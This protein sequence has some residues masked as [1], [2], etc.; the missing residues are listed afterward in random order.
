MD[1]VELGPGRGTLIRDALKVWKNDTFAQFYQSIKSVNLIERSAQLRDKQCDT[2]G[3][4]RD[5]S[6]YQMAETKSANGNDVAVES[7]EEIMKR[8]MEDAKLMLG[9]RLDN[10]LG[11]VKKPRDADSHPDLEQT[12]P[13]S[14]ST[15]TSSVD[16]LTSAKLDS[17]IPVRWHHT[18]PEMESSFPT[19]HTTFVICQEL[20]DALPIHVFEYTKK[21]WREKLVDINDSKDGL[22]IVLSKG[23]TVAC[24]G[25]LGEWIEE[26]GKKSKKKN[27]PE[28]GTVVEVSPESLTVSLDIATRINRNG[29]AAVIVDYGSAN[30]CGGETLRGFLSHNEVSI[31]ERPGE[32][33]VTGDVDFRRIV[34]TIGREKALDSV[35]VD[36]VCKQG[37]W[38][39]RMGIGER[40]SLLI[41]DDNVSEEQAN[42][43]YSGFE[44]LVGGSEVENGMGEVY[45]VLTLR[46]RTLRG[47]NSE[48]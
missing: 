38:L 12:V 46:G 24:R 1:V 16:F 6:S 13:Q 25:L 7:E 4:E 11:V 19:D 40:A 45:K 48:K 47:R 3:A 37:E 21:G 2:L 28:V 9:A 17:K 23:V 10:D 27:S 34:E 26:D 22:S 20:L 5:D 42:D 44:R 18:F 14:A 15:A 43:I 8:E 41:E 30:Y 32:T 39:M 31:L 35:T 29:G 36:P 33:D